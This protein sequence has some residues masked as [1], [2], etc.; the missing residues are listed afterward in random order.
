MISLGLGLIFL[1][2]S[3]ASPFKKDETPG[4]RFRK[5][6]EREAEYCVT[7]K[8]KPTNRRCDI[9]KLQ[10]ADPLATEEGRFAHS[11][12]IPSPVPED[13]G[14]K[15][16]MTPEQY[17]DHLCKTESGE[18][19]YK[20]VENVEGLYMM[21][22]RKEATDY[23][24]EHLYALE[25]PYGYTNHEA[26]RAEY[27]FVSP[28]RYIYFERAPQ[29]PRFGQGTH[30]SDGSR[31][32]AQRSA[33]YERFT[34]YDA[35][36]LESM[37][38]E[39]VES[40]ESRYGFTWRGITRPHDRE[41]GIAGGELIVL[42]LETNEVLGVRRGY[43]RSGMVRNNLTGIWWLTGQTCPAYG[44]RNGRNKDFDFSY[45]FIG[46]VLKPKNYE[47]SFK[48]LTNGK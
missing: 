13:S 29:P 39:P 9:T 25:D 37:K 21:R 27:G 19:I 43:I 33:G 35:R 17:F 6:I 12:K 42:N 3:G 38:R 46:K 11:I 10:P 24:L 31:T 22:P 41:L 7:H 32:A 16:E 23:E 48:E 14:Y 30:Q 5:A 40:R 34:G 26:K 28:N 47:Q 18:F 44:Y 4:E 2:S 15:L 45:W 20:T 8:I 1:T 36:H